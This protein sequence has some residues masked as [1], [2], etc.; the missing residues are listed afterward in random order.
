MICKDKYIIFIRHFQCIKVFVFF[1]AAL[2]FFPVHVGIRL[3]RNK[4]YVLYVF[5]FNRVSL[6][7]CLSPCCLQPRLPSAL[8]L[9][10]GA[11]APCCV[12]FR[13]LHGGG[14]R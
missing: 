1:V 9:S 2:F 3:F 14:L 12:W 6:S 11:P 5:L 8:P 4:R 13:R 10:R 7:V